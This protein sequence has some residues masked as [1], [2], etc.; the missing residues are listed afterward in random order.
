MNVYDRGF[1][2]CLW[3]TTIVNH[4]IMKWSAQPL[5]HN[6]SCWLTSPF[7]STLWPAIHPI[8]PFNVWK[9]IGQNVSHTGHPIQLGTCSKIILPVWC[10][11]Q[12]TDYEE[13]RNVCTFLN[14]WCR[15]MKCSSSSSAD[16]PWSLRQQSTP[17]W[18]QWASGTSAASPGV[19]AWWAF[20]ETLWHLK[21]HTS[22]NHVR[23]LHHCF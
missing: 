2:W 13:K 4:T 7:K 6:A 17:R 11:A 23:E 22:T 15:E 21:I 3:P 19:H 1:L 20:A 5:N 16:S 12:L 18:R 9:S 14:R 10:A 8:S